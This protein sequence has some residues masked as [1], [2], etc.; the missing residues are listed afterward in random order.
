MMVAASGVCR[1]TNT[2]EVAWR[3]QRAPKHSHGGIFRRLFDNKYGSGSASEAAD[4]LYWYLRGLPRLWSCAQALFLSQL[5]C[6]VRF[7]ARVE[8]FRCQNHHI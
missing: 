3:S 2:D 1:G 8:D 5:C 6:I 4:H 7:G